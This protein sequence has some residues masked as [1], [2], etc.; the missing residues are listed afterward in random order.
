MSRP[1]DPGTG[2]LADLLG[3]T[4]LS[5]SGG[6]ASFEVAVRP[7][8]MNPH[9]VVHGGVIATLADYAMG[10]ALS[11]RLEG[12]ERCATLEVKINYLASVSGGRLRADASVVHRGRRVAVLEA[13][14]T[15][16]TGRLVAVGLGSFAILDAG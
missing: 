12:A 16:D 8:H 13:R 10:G 3:V 4:R 14:V 9:A 11:S 2:P 7:E 15:D 5:M 6:Q 1:D